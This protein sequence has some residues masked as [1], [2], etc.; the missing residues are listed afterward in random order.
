MKEEAEK[1]RSREEGRRG[2]RRG[3]KGT[4]GKDVPFTQRRNENEP[5]SSYEL[6]SQQKS[7]NSLDSGTL[8]QHRAWRQLSR[9]RTLDCEGLLSKGWPGHP[10]HTLV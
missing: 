6:E 10:N 7:K 8:R 5:V 1:V 3:R 9:R 4:K 2:E